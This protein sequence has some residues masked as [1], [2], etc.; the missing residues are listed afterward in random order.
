MSV[1]A[2]VVID[3]LVYDNA[4]RNDKG[5]EKIGAAIASF[6]HFM[7]RHVISISVTISCC[8]LWFTVCTSIISDHSVG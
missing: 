1:C 7:F 3:V 6:L 8:I 2:F 4:V 5:T